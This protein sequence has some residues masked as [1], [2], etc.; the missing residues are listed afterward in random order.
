MKRRGIFVIEK[1]VVRS[2]Q[3]DK[4]A[5]K[6]LRVECAHSRELSKTKHEMR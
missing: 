3:E 2:C 1:R 5:R 4:S 6:L